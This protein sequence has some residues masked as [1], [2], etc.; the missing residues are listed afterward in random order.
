MP[1]RA[2]GF[3]RPLPRATQPLLR[4]VRGGPLE[5]ATWGEALGL[6]ADRFSALRRER[7]GDA[8]ALFS[9][10]KAT[11]ELNFVAQKF[12]RSVLS[13]NNIDSCNRT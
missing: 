1:R 13:T 12:A 2:D 11:N 8:F 10:S 4:R 7:G 6:I 5:P 3:R 9:C